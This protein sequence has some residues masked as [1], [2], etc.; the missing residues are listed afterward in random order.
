MTIDTIAPE[1]DAAVRRLAAIP[2]RWVSD[3]LRAAVL[4]AAQASAFAASAA[5]SLVAAR[6]AV[7][8]AFRHQDLAAVH[9]AAS[10]VTSAE[11]VVAA[12]PPLSPVHDGDAAAL[13]AQDLA[14]GIAA[15][16]PV[17]E[18]AMT[19]EYDAYDTG[20]PPAIKLNPEARAPVQLPA[21]LRLA[22]RVSE[23]RTQRRDIVGAVEYAQS[24]LVSSDTLG[25]LERIA[26][27]IPALRQVAADGAVVHA[28]VD[29]ANR[30]RVTAGLE[31]DPQQSAVQFSGNMTSPSLRALARFREQRAA[32]AEREVVPA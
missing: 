10:M 25:A 22:E 20:W 24:E 12:L 14:A 9:V 18:L 13:A 3:E 30:E 11:W 32:V 6:A 26:L 21:E 1:L 2:S 5:Q 27:L 15:V 31:W 29:V 28:A 8:E 4:A 16:P 7:A 17:P 23:W 19:L